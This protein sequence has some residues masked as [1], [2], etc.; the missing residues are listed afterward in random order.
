[1]VDRVREIALELG[2][3]RVAFTG[4]DAAVEDGNRLASWSALG[5]AAGM[6]WLTRD[7]ARRAAPQAFLAEAQSVI[8]LA[9]SYRAGNLP[10]GAR[11][12]LWTGGALCLGN[13]LSR[14][15]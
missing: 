1:M 10:P 7:P 2:F 12:G 3:D 5:K 6:A 9:V 4:P 14:G 15:H 11:L 13:G 8:T